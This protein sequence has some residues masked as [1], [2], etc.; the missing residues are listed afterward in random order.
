MN[1]RAVEARVLRVAPWLLGVSVFIHFV[2]VAMQA[3]MTMVD[4]MVYRDGSP[5]LLHGTLYDWHLS[6]Y[7]E[8]FALPFTYPPF[9]AVVFLPLSW[10]P[11]VAVRWLWQ[12]VS[13]ACLWWLV[14]LSL[15]LIAKDV[16]TDR[17]RTCGGGARCCGRGWRSGS[18]RC[19]PP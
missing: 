12:V 7:S 5:F 1:V 11:W 10:L 9:A 15:R 8:Q 16:D 13:V 4:L 17:P 14:R 18:S 19:V 6:E 3:K 2:L